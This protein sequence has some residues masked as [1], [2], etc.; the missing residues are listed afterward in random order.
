MPNTTPPPAPT[1]APYGRAAGAVLAFLLIGLLVKYQ[2]L[3]LTA[4]LR[5]AFVTPSFATGLGKLWM[6]LRFSWQE[7]A[8]A[9]LLLA[10]VL[11]WQRAV[12]NPGRS[13]RL[14]LL[15]GSALLAAGAALGVLGIKYY[16]LYHGHITVAEIENPVMWARQIAASARES[17]SVVRA[18]IAATALMLG[19][20][21]L[22]AWAWR[23]H[24]ARARRIAHAALAVT[25][26]AT[27]ATW[28]AGRP[29]LLDAR[30]EPNPM[31]W[32]VRGPHATY[33]DLPPIETLSVIGPSRRLH[34]PRE[35]PRNMI[36]V[37]LESAAANAIIGYNPDARAGARLFS[38]HGDDI[39]VFDNVYAVSPN[40]DAAIVSV[41][42]GRSPIPDNTTALRKS[43]GWPTLAE[44]VRDRGFETQFLLSSPSSALIDDLGS[45]G[46]DR[47]VHMDSS[48]PRR[49]QHIRLAWGYDDRLLVDEVRAFLESRTPGS[50]PFLLLLHTSNTHHPYQSGLMPGL[51]DDPDQHVRYLRLLGHTMD[52]LADLYSVLKASGFAET[53]G[54]FAYGDHGEAFGEHEGNYIHSKELFRENLHVP[55]LLLHPRRLGLP[56]RIDQ[57]GSLDDIMPTTLDLLGIDAPASDGMSLLFE[58]PE[59]IVFMS[60]AYGP[61]VVGFRDRR[62]FYALSRT[63]RELLFDYVD[64]PLERH[65]LRERRPDVVEAFR[66]RLGVAR[67]R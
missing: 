44:I 55:V 31:V 67:A 60:T 59:R 45:R 33:V 19:L 58:A 34:E 15:A 56:S 66:A 18:G 30:L 11:G 9:T 38:E 57:L 27:A 24:H 13:T 47:L 17:E 25:A 6:A 8:I 5:D 12:P 16:A 61:G 21:W 62:Y 49:E 42:T 2:E 54:L 37:V 10:G 20:P 63:G 46:F 64:D 3:G 26:I 7:F 4:E 35:R 39:T 65:N 51:G 40:S 32:F 48:W 52:R 23:A 41:L 28:I 36:L 22:G 50:P 43:A 14:A 29:V 1:A 53:T